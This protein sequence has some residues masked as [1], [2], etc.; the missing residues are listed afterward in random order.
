[1]TVT[2]WINVIDGVVN[3]IAIPIEA[4]RIA[5]IRN[6]GIWA[7]KPAQLRVIVS[8]AIV[9]EAG[10]RIKNLA[11]EAAQGVSATLGSRYLSPR[12]VFD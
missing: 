5:D 1:V 2:I 10:L 9:V 11:S 3:D 7:D 4:L 12:V 6:R 8:A